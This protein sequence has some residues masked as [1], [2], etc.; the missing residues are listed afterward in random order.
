MTTD[1]K[2]LKSLVFTYETTLIDIP[3]FER[4]DREIKRY[5]ARLN[6]GPRVVQSNFSHPVLQS[7]QQHNI[8][9]LGALI[10]LMD[11]TIN[12]NMMNMSI[13]NNMVDMSINNNM[14]DMS[15]NNNAMN[16]YM[17]IVQGARE[18]VAVTLD[19]KQINQFTVKKYSECDNLEDDTCAICQV[20]YEPD[21]QLTILPCNGHHRYHTPCIE[22]WLS[23]FSKKCPSCRQ[24]LDDTAVI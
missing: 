6:S 23:K 9:N 2:I 19:T 16:M 3:T 24:N 5:I 4:K 8:H 20:K 11:M 18:D 10:G 13:N 21:D 1:L 17:N 15:I 7:F 14:V 12:N 22:E